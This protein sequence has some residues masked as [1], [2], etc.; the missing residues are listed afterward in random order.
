MEISAVIG[1]AILLILGPVL[2]KFADRTYK[3]SK[4]ST[5]YKDLFDEE[6]SK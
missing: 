5:L 6:V 2:I 3:A 1:L 4:D